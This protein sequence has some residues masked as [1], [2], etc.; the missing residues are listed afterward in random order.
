M[1]RYGWDHVSSMLS[2][3]II[4]AIVCFVAQ[5]HIVTPASA[6]QKA[7][8]EKIVI[9]RHTDDALAKPVIDTE[10]LTIAEM[11][12]H[13][14]DTTATKELRRA[15]FAGRSFYTRGRIHDVD[16]TIIDATKATE[17]KVTLEGSDRDSNKHAVFVIFNTDKT[18][19]MKLRK[20]MM[21]DVHGMVER[22]NLFVGSY[23]GHH[24]WTVTLNEAACQEVAE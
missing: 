20:G 8:T 12:D 23:T 15:S 11:K 1:E 22:V 5:H 18:A 17:F 21:V 14:D 2:G 4:G 24:D 6:P 3:G 9:V 16:A 7:Q 10:A 13:D 19:A